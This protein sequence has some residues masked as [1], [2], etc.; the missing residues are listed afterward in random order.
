MKCRASRFGKLGSH[1]GPV[2]V[3]ALPTCPALLLR[4]VS[5]E[6]VIQKKTKDVHAIMFIASLFIRLKYQ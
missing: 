4:E 3:E 6:E 1:S 2:L 5:P